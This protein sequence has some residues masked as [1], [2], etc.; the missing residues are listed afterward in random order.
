MNN[1]TTIYKEGKIRTWRLGVKFKQIDSGSHVFSKRWNKIHVKRQMFVEYGLA[2]LS[3]SQLLFGRLSHLFNNY[4]LIICGNCSRHR[5]RKVKYTV[6]LHLGH[7]QST[8][9]CA[10]VGG[11]KK[12]KSTKANHEIYMGVSLSGVWFRGPFVVEYSGDISEQ[13][14]WAET[15]EPIWGRLPG[16]KSCRPLG[17]LVLSLPSL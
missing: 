6:I 16:C 3:Q 12:R 4:T 5:W 1:D 15:P 9:L 17:N 2:F 13:M 14:V 10:G 7:L 11:V 8:H